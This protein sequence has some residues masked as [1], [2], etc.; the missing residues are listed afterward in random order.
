MELKFQ[1]LYNLNETLKE[2]QEN[3]MPFKLG[4]I[5]AKNLGL[6]ESELNF[7]LEQE[8][9]FALKY[10]VVNEETGELESSAPGVFKIKDGMQEECG[11]ARKELDEFV[12]KIDLRTIPVSLIENL[13][14]TPKQL[15]ALEVI[16]EE[17]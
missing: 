14:F 13:D 16:I 1:Q 11:I 9:Q 10:L 12:A 7:Y 2:L 4:L 6:L 5:I 17:E 3:K 15:M 8:R